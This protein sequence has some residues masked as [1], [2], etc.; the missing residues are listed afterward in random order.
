M[1]AQM[2]KEIKEWKCKVNRAVVN[3]AC[4]NNIEYDDELEKLHEKFELTE[5]K[6]E[7]RRCMEEIYEMKERIIEYS[8]F[9]PEDKK[10]CNVCNLESH[11]Y[12]HSVKRKRIICHK[13]I[14]V[15]V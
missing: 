9:D 3:E 14:G 1:N 13:C 15:K 5:T 4:E 10:T 2:K 7:E 11:D 12:V 6:E 8:Y